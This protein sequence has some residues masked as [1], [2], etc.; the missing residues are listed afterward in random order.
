MRNPGHAAAASGTT[1]R[2]MAPSPGPGPQPV[3]AVPRRRPWTVVAAVLVLGV[4]AGALVV[5]LRGRGPEIPAYSVIERDGLRYEYDALAGRE[6][7]LELRA[8]GEKPVDVTATRPAEV[9]RFREELCRSLGVESLDE[10]REEHA[11]AAESLKR[12]GYL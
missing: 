5:G 9:Q 11:E 4:A 8:A 6:T 12:L 3:P 2:A 10:I 7:L 1:G